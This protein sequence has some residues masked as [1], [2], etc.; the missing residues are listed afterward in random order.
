M[1]GADEILH[2][3]DTLLVKGKQKDL[4]L[5]EGLQN[6][7][8]E[9]Q[10]MPDL[11]ELE[12]E[13]V[14]LEEV[15]LSPHSTLAGKSLRD[16]NF[17]FKYGLNVLAIWR[18][19]RAYR[20]NF[21]DLPLRFG[22]AILLYGPRKRLRILGSEP[23]FLVLTEG[24]QEAPRLEKMPIALLIMGV[25]LV[26]AIFGWLPIAI[27]AI[28]GVTLMILTGCLTMDEAY[29]YIEW[30]AIFLIAGMIPIGIAL[31]QTG[32]AQFLAQGMIAAIGGLGPLAILAGFFI[33]ASMASQFMPNPVV[34]V[35]LAPIALSTARD[36]GISPYTL[37][38][39][40]AVSASAAFL[41]PI[42]HAANLMVMGPGGY[43][44]SDYI[45]IGLHLTLIVLFVVMLI[46]P[47]FWPF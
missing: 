40:V 2:E 38:M 23:D 29:R 44:F 46:M 47:V 37:M 13:E 31:E 14:G 41:S 10:S 24:A 15:M 26:P 35:L 39:T 30:K 22:D 9:T 12:S 18:E 33:L 21:S 4:Q 7:E 5:V 43:R 20:S 36:L 28:I 8:I 45:K 32:T 42:G 6:L 17:R 3:G 27:S 19:G 16:L 34:A 1:P 25:V 11:G